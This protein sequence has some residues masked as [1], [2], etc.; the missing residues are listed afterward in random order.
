MF[1]ASDYDNLKNVEGAKAVGINAL[2]FENAEK[3]KEDLKTFN[4]A[5]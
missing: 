4:I 2:R 1:S 3:L 5:F